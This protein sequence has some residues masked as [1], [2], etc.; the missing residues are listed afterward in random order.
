MEE[1]NMNKSITSTNY[2]RFRDLTKISYDEILGA[3]FGAVGAY[4]LA[5][6]IGEVKTAYLLFLVSNVFWVSYAL[7]KKTP[8]LLFNMLAMT[9][10]TLVGL[11]N[12]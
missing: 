7:R 12:W 11:N 4:L 5:L 3:L 9:G 1:E 8:W 6:N 2:G 10:A